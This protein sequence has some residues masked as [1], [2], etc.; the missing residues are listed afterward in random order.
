MYGNQ[1]IF[2]EVELRAKLEREKVFI[3]AECGVNWTSLSEAKKMIEVFK[4][5][6]ASACKFQI[7]K[8]EQVEAHPRAKELASISLTEDW[9]KEL[10]DHGR[11]VGIEVFFTPMYPEAVDMLKKLKVKRFKIRSGDAVNSELLGLVLDTKG[12][13]FISVAGDRLDWDTLDEKKAKYRARLLYCVQRYPAKDSEVHLRQVFPAMRSYISSVEYVGL[14]DHAVGT[15]CS[16]CAVAMGARIIEKHVMLDNR[17][18]WIDKSVSITPVEF[19][20]MVHHIR[21]AEVLRE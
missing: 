18:D 10:L 8:P 2:E 21:R 4:E 14:S 12:E 6:G 15:T 7:Y 1:S 9:A 5:C 17:G 13:V 16:I 19:K 3:V 11:E 20:D